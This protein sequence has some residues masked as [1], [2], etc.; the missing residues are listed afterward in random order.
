MWEEDL[1]WRFVSENVLENGEAFDPIVT[2]LTG[3]SKGMHNALKN[4]A[5]SNAYCSALVQKPD[6]K[7]WFI[8]CWFRKAKLKSKCVGFNIG[9]V[10]QLQLLLLDHLLCI[11]LM[12]VELPISFFSF[13]SSWY[14]LWNQDPLCF[15]ESKWA[16]NDLTLPFE[17]WNTLFSLQ[18]KQ[19]AQW[20]VFA[21]SFR[22]SLL[23]R[24]ISQ[25]GCDFRG[26]YV[27]LKLWR[28]KLLHMT[29]C[30]TNQKHPKKST[31][32][33]ANVWQTKQ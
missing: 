28:L 23:N 20:R 5:V 15:S 17:T 6:E 1:N 27:P 19:I 21:P 10:V 3:Y 2:S 31:N 26:I 24:P 8:S 32:N 33:N 13:I 30:K 14:F 7:F 16:I 29:M 25:I 4:F 22:V 18:T 12:L 9:L 11:G